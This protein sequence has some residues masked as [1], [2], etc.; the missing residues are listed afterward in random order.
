LKATLPVYF[1]LVM[2]IEPLL[3]QAVVLK[4]GL[5][6]KG[7]KNRQVLN[8]S[9]WCSLGLCSLGYDAIPVTD[10]QALQDKGTMFL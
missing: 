5:M 7:Q 8:F 6:D 4:I 9:W 10:L 3:Q 1:D 2:E